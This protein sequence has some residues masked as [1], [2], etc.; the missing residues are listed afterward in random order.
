MK[1]SR[2]FILAF[3]FPIAISAQSLND[4]HLG[5]EDDI[6]ACYQA[7]RQNAFSIENIRIADSLYQIGVNRNNPSIM[8]A[9]LNLEMRAQLAADNFERFLGTADEIEK[10]YQDNPQTGYFYFSSHFIYVQ[11]LLQ[12]NMHVEAA[13]AARNMVRHADQTNYQY[14][15]FMAYRSLAY[16]NIYNK[17][18]QMAIES[19]STAIKLT[20]NAAGDMRKSDILSSKL[21]LVQLLSSAERFVEASQVLNSLKEDP[22]IMDDPLPLDF[23]EALMNVLKQDKK[24][25]LSAYDRL[26]NNPDYKNEIELDRRLW[27]DTYY[28]MITENPD[29]ALKMTDGI[30]NEH[31]RMRIMRT[32]YIEKGDFAKAYDMA[33]Q[34]MA[35]SDSLHSAILAE[36]VAVMET[37]LGNGILKESAKY[38]RVRA[39]RIAYLFLVTI[40]SLFL[41]FLILMYRRKAGYVSKLKKADES[42]SKLINNMSHEIRTPLNAIVGFSQLLSLPDGMLTPE[43][44]NQY[45]KY[46]KNNSSMLTLLVNDILFSSD[47]NKRKYEI[48]TEMTDPTE[49]IE[50]A[51]NSVSYLIND[52]IT[53][54]ATSNVPEDFKFK[55][56]PRRV[57]Q[58]LINLIT[59]AEKNT[60]FG[61]ITIGVSLTENPGMVSFSVTDTGCGVPADKAEIIFNRFVKLDPSKSG[62]GIGLS[63]CREISRLLNGEIYLDKTYTG[64]ARFVLKLP[65]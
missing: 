29:S 24:A 31:I 51:K 55:T 6:Y 12:V 64:G 18:D 20:E 58:I 2:L 28:I 54:D 1:K 25:F 17:N 30:S 42:K 8:A 27:V 21:Q 37:E 45:A 49:I 35:F 22:L 15:R 52:K 4:S 60:E 53:L 33:I 23:Q 43:E 41:I 38:E 44:K 11:I 56:D 62:L 5:L 16:V 65:A 19:L 61:S 7:A 46:V 14:G 3:L 36:D 32:C 13:V 10:I 47:V 50:M 34:E 40:L 48:Q 9:A 63:L 59:N 26:L 39:Q 57:Q